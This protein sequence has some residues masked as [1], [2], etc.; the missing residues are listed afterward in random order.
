MKGKIKINKTRVN[1]P[2]YRQPIPL[3]SYGSSISKKSDL[4]EVLP[5]SML[6]RGL[7]MQVGVLSK[8][9]RRHTSRFGL[10]KFHTIF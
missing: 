2:T 1:E 10:K 6:T 8:L 3:P 5:C 4:H 9:H 7:H